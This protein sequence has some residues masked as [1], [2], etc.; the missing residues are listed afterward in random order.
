[1]TEINTWIHPGHKHH[2][3]P[4]RRQ[5]KRRDQIKK[6]ISSLKFL[7][8]AQSEKTWFS[9]ANV[10]QIDRGT[11]DQ[12]HHSLVIC[13]MMLGAYLDT[14]TFLN[15]IFLLCSLDSK[16]GSLLIIISHCTS[17]T[18]HPEKIGTSSLLRSGPINLMLILQKGHWAKLM[19]P[20][21]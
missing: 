4:A 9:T 1:M 21:K 2:V 13:P 15:S 14:A 8:Q 19:Y 3:V 12:G 18:I 20:N 10:A 16:H 5:L 6:S 17:R 7:N 11:K